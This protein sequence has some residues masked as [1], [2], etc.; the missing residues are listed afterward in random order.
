MSGGGNDIKSGGAY[1]RLY[2]KNNDFTKGL[3]NASKSLKGWAVA[4]TSAVQNVGTKLAVG[5]AAGLSGV[6]I[7][8]SAASAVILPKRFAEAGQALN[9]MALS[10]KVSA[11]ALSSL[12]YVASQTGQTVE[13][14]MEAMRTGGLTPQAAKR[15]AELRKESQAL[16][17]VWSQFD[18]TRAVALIRQF[19][20]FGLIIGNLANRIGSALAPAMSI[21][22]NALSQGATQLAKWIQANQA[23]LTIGRIF[24]NVANAIENATKAMGPFVASLGAG[25]GDFLRAMGGALGAGKIGAALDLV[26]KGAKTLFLESIDSVIVGF[27]NLQIAAIRLG[28]TIANSIVDAFT[29]IKQAWAGMI[30]GMRS[31]A[32]DIVDIFKGIALPAATVQQQRAATDKANAAKDLTANAATVAGGVATKLGIA[33]AAAGQ[34]AGIQ[35]G[36]K[37][38]MVATAAAKARGEFERAKLATK[39]LEPGPLERAKAI[40]QDLVFPNRNQSAQGTFSGFAAGQSIGVGGYDQQTAENTGRM[41][42]LMQQMLR[43]NKGGFK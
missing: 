25:L 4:T 17:L 24:N 7:A 40:P 23:V 21:V 18:I 34:I 11:T 20:A 43:A 38:N 19:K 8:L 22:L 12:D 9:T 15:I 16:G 32:L 3:A 33:G 26:A 37:N 36:Q 35:A 31:S 10:A 27:G 1:V 5:L 42:A 30:A 29:A 6:G 41:V 13:S 14:L 28:V 39:Y 2:T